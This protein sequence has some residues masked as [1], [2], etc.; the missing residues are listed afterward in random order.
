[1]LGERNLGWVDFEATWAQV[2]GDQPA[3]T[4]KRTWDSDRGPRR[5]PIV[6][7][8]LAAAAVASC[9]VQP[10]RWIVPHLAV[11]AQFDCCRWTCRVTQ[12]VQRTPLWLASWLPALDKSRGSKSVEVRRVW[13][14]C[15]DRLPFMAR[16]DAVALD[17]TLQG[18]DVS[19]ARLGWSHAVETA[20]ADAC[21]F[22]GGPVPAWR[23]ICCR[24]AVRFRFVRSGGPSFR[25]VRVNVAGGHDGGDTLMYHYQTKN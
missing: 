21:R 2:R 15:D 6:V 9:Q 22:A 5:D 10:D 16:A 19:R 20:L 24:S 1:M 12:P 4:C 8:T 17:D 25:K 14:V 3:V 7:C 18:G 11:G 13:E 23:F